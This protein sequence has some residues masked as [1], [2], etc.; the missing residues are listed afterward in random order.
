MLAM[1]YPKKT[2]PEAIRAVAINLLEKEGE[3]ALTIR[4]VAS[5]LGLAPNAL[6]RHF[7]TRDVLIAAIADEVAKRL[8]AAIN[9][10]LGNQKPKHG[11]VPAERQVRTFIEVYIKFARSHPTL[12]QTLMTDMAA[13]EK[14]LPKPLGH[15]QLWVKVVE[16]LSP[17]I[18]QTHAAAAAVTLWSFV[19]GMLTLERANLL[20]GKKPS[21]VSGFG[22]AAFLKGLTF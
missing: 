2:S 9:K 7:A 13:A 6:Y 22:I 8:L 1:A 14:D 10:A 19:H 20:G 15:D 3:A 11:K 18:G 4:R 17:L 21:D 16:I 12:Y 5:E